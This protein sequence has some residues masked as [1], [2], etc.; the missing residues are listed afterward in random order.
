MSY[1]TSI[2]TAVPANR[3]TQLEIA[4]F[5]ARSLELDE[6]E[7]RKLIALYRSTKI[8]YRHSVLPDYGLPVE[9]YQFYP[10][11]PNLEPFPSVAHRMQVYKQTALP[12]CVEATRGLSLEGVTHLITVSCTGMY[13]PGLD[14][15]L[16]QALGLSTTIQ[17]TA[18][19]FMGCYGAFNGL[20]VA[21]DICLANPSAK[22]LLVSV[23]LCTLHFQKKKD[24]DFLLSNALFSD[25]A[26][27]VIIQA[28]APH[29][30]V[31]KLESFFCDLFIEGQSDMAWHIADFGFEM[32]LTSYVPQLIKA[33]INQLVESLLKANGARRDDI[34][35]YAIH[36]GGRA[37][38]ESVE[39]AL[40]IS[41]K[42]NQASYEVLR[43]YGNMSSTTILFVL[44]RIL[45]QVKD[46]NKGCKILSCAFG[47]GLTVESL[48]AK[49]GV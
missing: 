19:N 22:V 17:R 30:K 23:E 1:I 2:E 44:K 25:G 16:V 21:N 40:G 39:I 5:M 48:I 36:P 31:L 41:P 45:E 13:A 29:E 43:E 28:K 6:V 27:A 3:F 18:I 24:I 34:Q 49:M 47:P 38:L 4:E 35:Y 32:T 14:I 33:G 7:K 37:I 11:T 20:K 12:L 9:S 26:A 15:D 42:D 8:Q 10:Q 46:D